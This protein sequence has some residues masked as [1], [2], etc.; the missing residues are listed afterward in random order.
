MGMYDTV[1]VG[2][3]FFC[4]AGHDLSN[5]DFQT[6]DLGETMGTWHLGKYLSGTPGGYGDPVDE[7]GFTGLISIY[8]SCTDCPAFV[9][10]STFNVIDHSVEFEVQLVAGCPVSIKMVSESVDAFIRNTPRQ[11]WMRNAYLGPMP[12]RKAR[13][14]SMKRF[15]QPGQPVQ[16]RKFTGDPA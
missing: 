9:Q 2:D 12:H 14:I 7:K 11:P 13:E 6:K 15:T 4:S 1:I 5:Q 10:G 16:W 3:G 8:T